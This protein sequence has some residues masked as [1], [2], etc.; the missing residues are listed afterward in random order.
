MKYIFLIAT[1][2]IANYS[3]FAAGSPVEFSTLSPK[4]RMA[5]VGATV[6]DS[7]DIQQKSLIQSLKEISNKCS[8]TLGV[9]FSIIEKDA[10]DMAITFKANQFTVN[11]LLAYLGKLSGYSITLTDAGCLVQKRSFQEGAAASP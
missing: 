3:C 6:I 1:L 7:V 8:A 4:E 2:W 10:P 5:I 9:G 11:Q